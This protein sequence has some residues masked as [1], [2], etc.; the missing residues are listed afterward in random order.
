MKILQNVKPRAVY[1]LSFSPD[2]RKLVTGGSGGIDIWDLQ[3]QTSVHLRS[4]DV[5]NYISA[6]ECDPLGRGFYLGDSSSIPRRIDWEGRDQQHLPIPATDSMLRWISHLSA[7]SDRLLLG[8]N[9]QVECWIAREVFTLVWGISDGY[10]HGA[11]W[12]WDSDTGDHVGVATWA[13]AFSQDGRLASGIESSG[14][15][16]TA[17]L[18]NGATG[19]TLHD[20]G[21][22]EDVMRY[23]MQFTPDGETLIGFDQKE[24]VLWNTASGER[25]GELRPGRAK[26]NGL[27]V[28][29]SG[30]F[31]VTGS[32]D[33][34]ACTWSLTTQRQMNAFKWTVGKLHSVA[35]SPDG[36]LAAAGGDKGQVVLWDIV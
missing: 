13:R 19:E 12:R 10:V 21:R 2:G 25:V 7:A 9:G 11:D 20:L 22:V 28:H 15:T 24:V 17:V 3:T 27:A 35:I 26:L 8:R 5:T 32:T 6:C 18:W 31:F 29:P 36:T 16:H 33:Q 30:E 1:C 14:A 23:R 4:P 34:S